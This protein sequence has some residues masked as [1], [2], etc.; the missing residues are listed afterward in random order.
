MAVDDV[1]APEMSDHAEADG[2]ALDSKLHWH[3]G[4][5]DASDQFFG[6]QVRRHMQSGRQDR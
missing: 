2:V 1:V 6:G 3:A 5:C 4:Y